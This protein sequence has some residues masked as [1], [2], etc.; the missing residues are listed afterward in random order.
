[1]NAADLKLELFRRIDALPDQVLE[2]VY[3]QLISVLQSSKEYKLSDEEKKA[4][5][6]ALAERDKGISYSHNQVMEEAA[7]RYPNLKFK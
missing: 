1:M 7:K 5:N 2:G 4:V 6:E 3:Q